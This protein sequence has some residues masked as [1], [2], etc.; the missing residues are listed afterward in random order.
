M[1][2][3]C[4]CCVWLTYVVAH[5]PSPQ[6]KAL[7]TMFSKGRLR[8]AIIGAR[9]LLHTQPHDSAVRDALRRYEEV[10]RQLEKAGARFPEFGCECATHAYRVQYTVLYISAS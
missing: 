2:R 9:A 5:T 6:L 3:A 7:E 8:S 1:W 4:I 10:G